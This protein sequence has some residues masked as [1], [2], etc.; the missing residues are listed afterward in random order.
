MIIHECKVQCQS[1]DETAAE[2]MGLK[3]DYKWLPFIFDM[4]IVDAAKLSDDDVNSS[5]YNCTT[6]FTR[7]GDRY[8]IDTD[9]REFFKKYIKYSEIEI[10]FKP[11]DEGFDNGEGNFEL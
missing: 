7:S 6:I 11:D 10:L 1:L 2:L 8:I 3:D 4:D 9:Y 5:T